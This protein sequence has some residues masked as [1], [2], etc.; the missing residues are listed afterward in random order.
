MMN[1]KWQSLVAGCAV[2]AALLFVVAEVEARRGGGGGGR[3]GGGGHSFSRSGPASG[4]SVRS[5]QVSRGQRGSMQENRGANRGD[6]SGQ[7]GDM[8]DD[9]SD[10]RDN[11]RDDRGDH[12]DDRLDHRDDA[13]EDRQRYADEV[14]DDRRDWYEDNY[15]YRRR[16]GTVV[17]V[18][19]FNSY[20]CTTTKVY[21]DGVTYYRCDDVWYSRAYHSGSVTYVVVTA[22]SGY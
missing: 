14:R 6:R 4:G 20:S 3:G 1:V 9:R 12:L 16:V 22:P 17:T 15:R 5:H 21:V 10:R 11:V 18:S 13:R 2:L 19:T 8:R 7:R